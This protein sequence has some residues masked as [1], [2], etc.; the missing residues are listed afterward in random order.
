MQQYNHMKNLILYKLD[1]VCTMFCKLF[2]VKNEILT[3][4][5]THILLFGQQKSKGW[6]FHFSLTFPTLC[7]TAYSNIFLL[8]FTCLLYIFHVGTS[9]VKLIYYYIFL[10]CRF[11][12]IQTFHF[13]RVINCDTQN[14]TGRYVYKNIYV[15]M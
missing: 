15:L 12:Y 13:S 8:V 10:G 2:L 5:Y 3:K 1:C 4:Y 9:I 6:F 14:L 11:P 7:S